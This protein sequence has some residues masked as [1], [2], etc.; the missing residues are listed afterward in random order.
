MARKVKDEVFVVDD[1]EVTLTNEVATA[2]QATIVDTID[3]GQERLMNVWAAANQAGWLTL[4]GLDPHIMDAGVT[5]SPD[6]E[7]KIVLFVSGMGD[8]ASWARGDFALYVRSKVRAKAKDE[9][10][11][12]QKYNELWGIELERMARRFGV[13]P[14]TLQN[15]ISTCIIWTHDTRV[16]GEYVRYKHHEALPTDMALENKHH[17]LRLCEENGWTWAR[18]YKVAHGKMLEDGTPIDGEEPKPSHFLNGL[19]PVDEQIANTRP[20]DMDELDLL[21]ASELIAEIDIPQRMNGYNPADGDTD[22]MPDMP[23]LPDIPEMPDDLP[24]EWGDI[25]AA[26]PE[27]QVHTQWGSIAPRPEGE[28]WVSITMLDGDL[29]TVLVQHA[30]QNPRFR[31]FFGDNSVF[32]VTADVVLGTIRVESI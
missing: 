4:V 17:L 24:A 16:A 1:G 22:E 12:P 32:E 3:A 10:W 29:S 30:Q 18:L 13:S 11:S 20:Q 26:P 27:G 7:D 14:K 19:V 5:L 25:G 31:F 2:P 15:N 21:D 9:N 28:E 8:A 23:P 6:D